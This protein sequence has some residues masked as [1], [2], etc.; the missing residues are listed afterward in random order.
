MNAKHES[1]LNTVAASNDIF[2]STLI[3]ARRWIASAV[4]VV[5]TGLMLAVVTLPTTHAPRLT[6]INGIH[7]TDLAPVEVTPSADDLKVASA[8]GHAA[9][10]VAANGAAQLGAQ[11]VMPYYSFGNTSTDSKE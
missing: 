6:W 10:G 5:M 2:V 1:H 9:V 3:P 11:L 8:L 4:A 7:V